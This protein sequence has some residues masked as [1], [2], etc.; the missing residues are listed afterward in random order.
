MSSSDWSARPRIRFHAEDALTVQSP[1]PPN[2]DVQPIPSFDVSKKIEGTFRTSFHG[3]AEPIIKEFG[4]KMET[5]VYP[6]TAMAIMIIGMIFHGLLPLEN[7]RPIIGQGFGSPNKW[8]SWMTVKGQRRM[9]DQVCGGS[10]SDIPN[11]KI[12]FSQAV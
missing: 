7:V 9:S 11:S 3:D 2:P 12:S 10:K 6:C 8:F 5:R 4:A 1:S